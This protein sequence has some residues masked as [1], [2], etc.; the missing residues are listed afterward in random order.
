MIYESVAISIVPRFPIAREDNI[1]R[2]R[3]CGEFFKYREFES[4]RWDLALLCTYIEKETIFI[5]VLIYIYPSSKFAENFEP[6]KVIFIIKKY[7]YKYFYIIYI[8]L[9][10][11]KDRRWGGKKEKKRNWEFLRLSDRFIYHLIIEY[12]F[13][14][15]SIMVELCSRDPIFSLLDG[16]SGNIFFK[17]RKEGRKENTVRQKN[18]SRDLIYHLDSQKYFFPSLSLSLE[19]LSSVRDYSQFGY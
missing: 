13:N 4:H 2:P 15:H 17:G 5:F 7:W 18:L 1:A 19:N 11:L 12:N 8:K 14:K 16:R 10:K 3:L 9:R 6:L